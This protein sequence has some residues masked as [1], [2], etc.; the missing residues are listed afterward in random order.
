MSKSIC[1]IQT[2]IGSSSA[3][4]D[5]CAEIMPDIHAYQIIDDS[6]LPEIIKAGGLTTQARQRMFAYYQQAESLGVSAIVHTCVVAGDFAYEAQPFFNTPIVR[7]DEGMARAAL[8]FA[9][10][11]AIVGT[12]PGS[13]EPSCSLFRSIATQRNQEISLEQLVLSCPSNADAVMAE[14]GDIATKVDAIAL[15]QP[16]MTG[17]EPI[18][19]SAGVP[20]LTVPRLGFEFIRTMLA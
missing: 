10:R 1:L 18:V 4:A 5:L 2:G 17:L 7:I 14:I 15:A 20:V 13:I 12:T 19:K 8:D 16:S 11:I 9:S 6:L 3:F